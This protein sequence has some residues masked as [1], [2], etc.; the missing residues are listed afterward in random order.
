M[1]GIEPDALNGRVCAWALS[2]GSRL[3]GSRPPTG[4]ST[5]SFA[6]SLP[7]REPPIPVG[8]ASLARHI[9]RDQRGV[10]RSAPAPQTDALAARAAPRSRRVSCEPSG[11]SVGS[12]ANR[13]ARRQIQVADARSESNRPPPSRWT[14]VGLLPC[15]QSNRELKPPP[16]RKDRRA[17]QR[18]VIADR[19]NQWSRAPA[20]GDCSPSKDVLCQPPGG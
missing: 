19:A 2:E 15:R 5:R 17:G 8:A 7:S 11:R 6:D 16:Q 4:R 14:F 20:A 13:P 10:G 18:G 1:L 3:R 9:G 12:E